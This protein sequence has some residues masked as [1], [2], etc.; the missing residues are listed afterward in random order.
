MIIND[1]YF[2]TI[3]D[4]IKIIIYIIIIYMNNT[5]IW[6]ILIQIK[7]NFGRLQNEKIFT[8]QMR[9]IKLISSNKVNSLVINFTPKWFRIILI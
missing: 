3:Y 6:I 5:Y 8:K 1:N 7:L 9:A 2:K 4:Q